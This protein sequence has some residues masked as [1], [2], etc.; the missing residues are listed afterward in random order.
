VIARGVGNVDRAYLVGMPMEFKQDATG[1]RS[2][3]SGDL[4]GG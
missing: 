1:E 3:A 2:I 4:F